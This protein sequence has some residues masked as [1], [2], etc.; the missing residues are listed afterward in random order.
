MNTKA[1]FTPG[2]W[3]HHDMEDATIV[4]GK[5]GIPIA[6]CNARNRPLEENEANARL[7][8]AAPELLTALKWAMDWKQLGSRWN[9]AGDAEREMLNAALA[10]IAK[11]EEEE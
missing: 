11:A 6:D 8:S 4:A 9:L 3:R 1:T 10:A 7:I 2:P 5:P